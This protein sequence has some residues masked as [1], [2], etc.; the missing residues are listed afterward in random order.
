MTLRSLEIFLKVSETL[1]MQAAARALYISAPSVSESIGELERECGARLFDRLNRRLYLTPAGEQMR[2]YALRLYNL[3]NEMRRQI[4]NPAQPLRLGVTMTV[5]SSVLLPLLHRM[6]Q[7]KPFVNVCNTR[8]VERQLLANKLD[9]GLVEGE[10]HDPNLRATPVFPDQL[11][12]ACAPG[13]SFAA[14]SSVTLGELAAEDLLMREQGSGTRE[15]L[16]QAL[17]RERIQPRMLWEC[18]SVD[19]LIRAVRESIG[20][21]VISRRLIPPDL[22]AVPIAGFEGDRQFSLVLHRDKCLTDAIR[23]AVDACGQLAAEGV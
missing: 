10:V 5:A 1:N 12:L 14:R 21:T 19:A 4:A 18:G 22:A 11:V 13:H 17:E 6:G 16:W 2:A 3:Y 7:P 8:D 23:K 15:R 20:V 9:L